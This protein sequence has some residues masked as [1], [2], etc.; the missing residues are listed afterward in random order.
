MIET[1]ANRQTGQDC[2]D[3]LYPSLIHNKKLRGAD[4]SFYDAVRQGEAS[5]PKCSAM[6][7]EVLKKTS[8]S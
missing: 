2:D 5:D 3:G 7:A 1:E 4:E 8:R 6:I